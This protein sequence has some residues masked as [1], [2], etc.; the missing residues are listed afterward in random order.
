MRKNFFPQNTVSEIS[1]NYELGPGIFISV[2]FGLQRE[3]R[4]TGMESAL[5][6]RKSYNNHMRGERGAIP[7]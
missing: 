2:L 7:E 4:S 5:T 3:L 6:S 1:N